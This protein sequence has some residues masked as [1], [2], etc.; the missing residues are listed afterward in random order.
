MDDMDK[1]HGHKFRAASSMLKIC[2]C[3]VHH[4]P[5]PS[6]TEHTETTNLFT[7]SFG[8]LF[9][10]LLLIFRWL[11]FF[12]F[13]LLYSWSLL[14]SIPFF[15]LFYTSFCVDKLL[16]SGKKWMGG[17]RDGHTV[18]RIFFSLMRVTVLR[19]K[20]RSANKFMTCRRIYK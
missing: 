12:P 19:L 18:N 7:L 6:I 16:A 9:L 20:G 14:R 3:I 5:F 1:Q 17:R 15:E 4:R 2:P 10:R 8:R 11:L 13:F